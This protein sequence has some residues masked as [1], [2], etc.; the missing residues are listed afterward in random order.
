M[1]QNINTNLPGI[2][3]QGEVVIGKTVSA[4]KAVK[5]WDIFICL[6]TVNDILFL[7]DGA[8]VGRRGVS[9]GQDVKDF[10][11]YHREMNRG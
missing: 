11:F 4:M 2:C 1:T 5:A 7:E 6:G 3:G 8:H 9:L 10:Q